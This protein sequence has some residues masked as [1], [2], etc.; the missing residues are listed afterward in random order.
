MHSFAL[1]LLL[2]IFTLII[3]L[4]SLPLSLY[5]KS[6]VFFMD[7]LLFFI[8]HSCIL[9]ALIIRFHLLRIHSLRQHLIY[10]WAHNIHIFYKF[11]L[12]S[13]VYYLLSFILLFTLFKMGSTY[14]ILIIILSFIKWFILYYLYLLSTYSHRILHLIISYI[15]LTLDSWFYRR[16]SILYLLDFSLFK[17]IHYL[18][19]NNI[20]LS[21]NIILYIFLI[22]ILWL[23]WARSCLDELN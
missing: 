15:L 21:F 11:T 9:F 17:G 20:Y 14:F 18:Y 6:Y 1:F 5:Y 16:S 19:F 23:L 13:S 4:L 2:F 22:S 3:Y 10:R 12:V 7:R 8:Y